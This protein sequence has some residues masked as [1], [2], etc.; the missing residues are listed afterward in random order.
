MEFSAFERGRNMLNMAATVTDLI[1]S[2]LGIRK[3]MGHLRKTP[4]TFIYSQRSSTVNGL[5]PLL[6][7]PKT[8]LQVQYKNG[9]I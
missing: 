2:L 4:S 9:N 7:K 8:S 5:L 1:S 3:P 6:A